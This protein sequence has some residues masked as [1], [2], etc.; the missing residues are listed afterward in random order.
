MKLKYI[1]DLPFYLSVNEEALAAKYGDIIKYSRSDSSVVF[2][3]VPDWISD[4]NL[5]PEDFHSL[6]TAICEEHPELID[7]ELNILDE[8]SINNMIQIYHKA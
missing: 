2:Y 6:F 5:F 3:K 1:L 7:D 8:R 4:D